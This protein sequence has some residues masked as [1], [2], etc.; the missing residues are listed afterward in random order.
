MVESNLGV[1]GTL[2]YRGSEVPIQRLLCQNRE[3]HRILDISMSVCSTQLQVACD[4]S[5]NPSGVTAGC[6][7]WKQQEE[8]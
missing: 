5:S 3:G 8:D 2:E 6:K 7:L 4:P 1:L